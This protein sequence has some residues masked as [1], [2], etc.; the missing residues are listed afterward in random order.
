MGGIYSPAL[1]IALN[2]MEMA[3]VYIAPALGKC[4]ILQFQ[5]QV[6]LVINRMQS[7]ISEA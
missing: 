5:W 3:L 1:G 4:G 6:R 7:L 2:I